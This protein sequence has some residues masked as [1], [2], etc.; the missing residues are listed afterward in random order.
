MCVCVCVAG[1]V[2]VLGLFH[3]RKARKAS[4]EMWHVGIMVKRCL[5]SD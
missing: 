2:I 5:G 1:G 4:E 3:S